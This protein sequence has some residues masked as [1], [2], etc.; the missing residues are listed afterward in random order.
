MKKFV[1]YNPLQSGSNLKESVYSALGNDC[2]QM[3]YPVHFPVITMINGYVDKG[4]EIEVLLIGNRE[5][6]KYQSNLS[7]LREDLEKVKQKK[8]FEYKLTAVDISEEELAIEHLKTY[9]RLLSHIHEGD[10]LYVCVTFGSKPT[11]IVE[12]MALTTAYRI[13]KNVSI[14]CIAYGRMIHET[15]TSFVYDITPLFH[16]SQIVNELAEKRMENPE[17]IISNL[18]NLREDEQ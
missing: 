2:L 9:T 7:V 13:K 5:N 6:D 1:T 12:M 10:D 17:E 18:L 15:K 4:E 16:M 3:D 14:G 8:P 11:P